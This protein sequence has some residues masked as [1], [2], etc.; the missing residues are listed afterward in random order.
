ME[1]LKLIV[2]GGRDF[3]DPLLLEKAIT[4]LANGVY[5]DKAVSIVSG[6]ARG[7]DMLGYQFAMKHNVVVYTMPADWEQFGKR[8]G[9]IRNKAMGDMAD[10]LLAFWDGE[11]RGTKQMID[12][13]N[14]LHK[15][16]FIIRYGASTSLVPAPSLEKE[17]TWS[18]NGG[19]QCSSKGDSR[20]SALFARM[21]DGRTIEQHYQCDVKGYQPGGTDWRLGKGKPPLNPEKDLWS[22]YLALWKTWAKH[23]PQLISQLANK[24]KEFD[25]VLSDTFATTPINQARALA[26]I[27][28]TQ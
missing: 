4:D 16:V 5:A 27:L 10:A 1:E 8:A 25:Y 28:N 17:V 2:A 3:A 20:F 24:A 6:M 19:Y 11:S 26:E 22:E 12:Y 9:M 23:N 14:S 15:P 21:P 18:R 13:M 7:A